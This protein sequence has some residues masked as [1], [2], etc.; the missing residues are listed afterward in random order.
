[1]KNIISIFIVTFSFFTFVNS[2]V[3][4]SKDSTFYTDSSFVNLF[5]GESIKY[6]TLNG[7]VQ[8]KSTYVNGKWH[9]ETIEYHE[10]GKVAKKINFV[11]GKQ[12][13]DLLEYHVNG[14]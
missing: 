11:D 7:A 3:Y 10:N 5:N 8:N 6:Y 9:G 2:Q 14:K 4:N 1:M 13:G 12:H